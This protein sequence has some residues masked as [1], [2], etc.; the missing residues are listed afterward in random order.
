[1]PKIIIKV[2][3]RPLSNFEVYLEKIKEKNIKTYERY[4]NYISP[5]ASEKTN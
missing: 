2:E 5:S 3:N 4:L 1:M